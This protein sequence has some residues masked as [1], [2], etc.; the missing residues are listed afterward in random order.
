M[1]LGH[2]E[3]ASAPASAPG[4][5]AEDRFV[6]DAL[7]R[8]AALITGSNGVA[9]LVEAVAEATRELL[10]ADSLSISQLDVDRRVIKTLINV[11]A[12]GPGEERRPVDETYAVEDFPDTLGFLVEKPVRRAST[13]V[14]DPLAEPAE[15]ALLRSLGMATSLKTPIVL[16]GRVWGELWAA[17]RPGAPPFTEDDGDVAKVVVALVSAGLA[18]SA[19][20]QVM[21]QRASTDPLTGL[22][23]RYFLEETFRRELAIAERAGHP[24][25][26]ILRDVD[27]F[28]A[29]NDRAGHLAGDEVLRAFGALL[30]RDTRASDII[31]RYGGDE[32]LLVLPGMTGEG[33]AERA[34]RLRR[35]VAALPLGE[36][37]PGI[38]VTATFGVASFPTHGRTFQELIAAADGALYAAKAEGRNRVNVGP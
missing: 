11:G 29:I 22:Y 38:G 17:R 8:L 14:D 26:V 10:H 2:D 32:F 9:D 31:C 21:Q 37:P 5:R 24:V 33:A 23:N 25:G 20:W 6:L 36:G 13:V 1:E 30:K 28:K 35:A 7:V 18:Q 16:D 15:L 12:L 27:H 34:E 19:A 4:L 3:E